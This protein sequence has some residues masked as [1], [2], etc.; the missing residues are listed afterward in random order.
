MWRISYLGKQKEGGSSFIWHAG[1]LILGFLEIRFPKQLAEVHVIHGLHHSMS[2]LNGLCPHTLVLF[3]PV[4]H[5]CHD[6]R[7]GSCSASMAILIHGAMARTLPTL[8]RRSAWT[9]HLSHSD[10]APLPLAPLWSWGPLHSPSCHSPLLHYCGLLT[11][12]S[13][14]ETSLPVFKL[15]KVRGHV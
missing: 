6:R 5:A 3:L 1:E 11:S 14:S 13:P 2:I 10:L 9:F 7:E 15:S 4:G 8:S 12:L